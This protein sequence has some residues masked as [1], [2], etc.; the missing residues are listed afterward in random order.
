MIAK[1][2]TPLNDA[3]RI[4]DWVELGAGGEIRFLS[5]RSELGQGNATALLQIG[6]DE[7][8]ILP[9]NARIVT[10]RTDLTPNEGFTVG[11]LSITQGGQAIRWAASALRR[12]VLDAAASQLS[13]DGAAL[14]IEKGRILR[15]GSDSGLSLVDLARAAD[16]SRSVVD[17][18]QPKKARDRWAE[19]REIPRIDFEERLAGA[20]FVHDMTMP[21]MLYGAPV[22]PPH[23][24]AELVA[25]DLDGL[26]GRGGV[27]D[28]VRD[29]SFVG[30][31]AGSHLA[32]ARAADWARA[33]GEWSVDGR[34]IGDPIEHIDGTDAEPE[35]MFE[36]GEVNRNDG[37]WIETMVSRPYILHASIGPSA[38]VARWDDDAVSVWTHSQ[39][40]FP[41]RKAIGMA[42]RIPEDRITVIHTSG[43][44]CYGHNGADDAA[45]DAVL[46]ARAVPGRPVKVIWSRVD[47]FRSAPMGPAMTTR[48]RALVGP[49]GKVKAMDVEVKSPPHSGRPSTN[50]TPNLRAA[51]YLSDPIPPARQSDPPLARGGGADRNAVPSYDIAGVRVRKRLVHDLPYRTSSLRS[52]GAFANVMAIEAV[53]HEVARE[54]GEDQFGFRL[55]HLEDPRARAVLDELERR[56]RRTRDTGGEA[57]GWGIGYARYKGTSG[58]GAVLARVTLEDAVRVTDVHAVADIGEVI[59]PDGARN[60]IEGGIVQSISWTLKEAAAFDG[61]VVA[62]TSWLD[63]PILRFS[64]VPR[65]DVTLIDRTE[66]PP[67]GAGEVSQA[68]A[69]AAVANA[70]REA[71]GVR[72]TRTPISREAI[73]AAASA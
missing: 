49:D 38:A 32:A 44:G 26:R 36:A 20:P 43:A 66:D 45:F 33:N 51:A 19:R 25:L 12:L 54:R 28:V 21:G 60:Q 7:L 72:V 71:L 10:A 14:R 47:E 53:M 61:S 4:S 9:E 5:G 37:E 42:L 70:V 46:L 16:L 73:I 56:S 63:Y 62:N 68:P 11:S 50:G 48:V 3:P 57:S 64:E 1:V 55:R 15:N 41:L 27:V 69:A 8:G 39:G 65:L 29:G 22:H 18:A 35:V 30:I 59:S 34:E 40:V 24:G 2:P 6:A 17:L 31:I 52:L 58:Y 13:C 23:I 67:L